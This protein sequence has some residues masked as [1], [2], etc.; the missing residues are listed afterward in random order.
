MSGQ[1]WEGIPPEMQRQANTPWFTSLLQYDP[2]AAMK[3][4]NQPILIV[5]GDLDRQVP[6]AHADKLATLAKARKKPGNVQ[7]AKFPT[8]NH[9]LVPA[10]T[11]EVDEYSKLETKAVSPEVSAKIAEWLKTCLLYTS[12]SPRDGLLSRMPSSA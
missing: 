6:T 7:V 5:Q 10:K 8:L 9:L 3:K 11:G 12:P 1:G 2:A 4:V